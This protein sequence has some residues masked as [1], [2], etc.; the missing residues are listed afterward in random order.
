VPSVSTSFFYSFLAMMVVS[1]LLTCSFASYV[2]LLRGASEINRL[3]ETVD[4]V[5]AE[6]EDALTTVTSHNATIGIVIQL[7]AKIGYREYWIRLANDSSRAWLEGGFGRTP[8]SEE[9]VYR[10]YLPRNAYVSGIFEGRYGI[11]LLNCFL[12]GSVPQLVL[13][14]RR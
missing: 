6:A 12:N 2:N 8:T 13:S 9:R 10:V 5:A 1:T 7:P 3:G 11:A 14:Q 4:K